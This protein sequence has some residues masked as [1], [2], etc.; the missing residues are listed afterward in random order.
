MFL[1]PINGAGRA[2]YKIV[3]SVNSCTDLPS[4]GVRLPVLR[5]Y[6]AAPG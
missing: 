1:N 2:A 4:P 5:T 3:L 6:T